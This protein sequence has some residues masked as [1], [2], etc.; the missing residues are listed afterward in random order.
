MVVTWTLRQ[1]VGFPGANPPPTKLREVHWFHFVWD[2][3]GTEYS[4]LRAP[5]VLRLLTLTHIFKVVCS[6]LCINEPANQYLSFHWRDHFHTWYRYSTPTECVS[7]I[8]TFDLDPYF[9]GHLLITSPKKNGTKSS[10]VVIMGQRGLFS[11]RGHSNLSS[12]NKSQFPHTFPGITIIWW[13]FFYVLCIFMYV[14]K[15]FSAYD[16]D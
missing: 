7:C 16:F 6:C 11:D 2:I 1:S 14:E 3:L 4:P 9:Q 15:P 12:R 5:R 8:T 13:Y 10:L